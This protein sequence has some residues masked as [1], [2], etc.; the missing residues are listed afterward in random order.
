MLQSQRIQFTPLSTTYRKPLEDL[1]CKNPLVMQNTLKGR[2][3]TA[4]ELQKI[5][6]DDFITTTDETVGFWCLTSKEDN[7]FIGV[8]GLLKCNYLGK[9]SYE[10][11]FILDDNFWGKGIATEIGKFW[12]DYAKNELNLTEILATASPENHASRRVLEKLDLQMVRQFTSKER[13]AR[14]LFSK[15]L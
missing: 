7:A 10:F 3:L 9:E 8:S 12:I 6:E 1:F 5:V 11:G 13:G 4:N 14:L 15:K 2:V